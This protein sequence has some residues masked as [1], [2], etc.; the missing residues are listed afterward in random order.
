MDASLH[1]TRPVHDRLV[2]AIYMYMRKKLY[3]ANVQIQSRT[4]NYRKK[5]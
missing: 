1:N 4:V 2:L 3:K 5:H